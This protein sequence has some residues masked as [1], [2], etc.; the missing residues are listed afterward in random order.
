MERDFFCK[1]NAPQKRGNIFRRNFLF[2]GF[3]DSDACDFWIGLDLVWFFVWIWILLTFGLGL[4]FGLVFRL[5]WICSV[6]G[7]DVFAGFDR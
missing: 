4:D 1:K 2:Y 5:D 6:L 3:M 7:L